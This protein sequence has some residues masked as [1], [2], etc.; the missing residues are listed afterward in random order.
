MVLGCS[1]YGLVERLPK[2]WQVHDWMMGDLMPGIVES[3]YAL[4]T[5][6]SGH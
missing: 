3:I 5:A 4:T 6:G 1:D 2:N